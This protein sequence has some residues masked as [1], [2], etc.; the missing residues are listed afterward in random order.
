MFRFP[1]VLDLEVRVRYESPSANDQLYFHEGLQSMADD[2]LPAIASSDEHFEQ[3]LT[4][5][6]HRCQGVQCKLVERKRLNI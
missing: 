2:E 5:D 3:F 6:L 1:Y 4:V